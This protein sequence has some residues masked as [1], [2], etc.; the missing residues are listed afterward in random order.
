MIKGIYN[1]CTYMSLTHYG[2]HDHCEVRPDV[3]PELGR[4]RVDQFVDEV[5]GVCERGLILGQHAGVDVHNDNL[6]FSQ[7][8]LEVERK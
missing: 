4:S 3:A 2:W 1:L 5:L 7:Q 8:F 6:V